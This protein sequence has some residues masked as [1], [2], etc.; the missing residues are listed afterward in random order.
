MHIYYYDNILQF[1]YINCS[2]HFNHHIDNFSNT[3]EF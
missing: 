3:D 1:D 2:G